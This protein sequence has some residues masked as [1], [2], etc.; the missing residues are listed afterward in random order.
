MS[1]VSRVKK[2]PTVTAVAALAV[3]ATLAGGGL[4][5]NAFAA[6]SSAQGDLAPTPLAGH[7]P[8]L[9]SE[10]TTLFSGASRQYAAQEELVRRCMEGKGFTY[11]K[12]PTPQS[13]V[14]PTVG[15]DNYGQSLQAASATG[16][17]SA[18]I[19]GDSP[20][21]ID[22]SGVQ[23]L[24]KDQQQ[25]WGDA[26]LGPGDAPEITV[27]IPTFGEV[28]T[29]AEGCLTEARRT[30]YG[31]I[32]Q[33]L[34]L[35][36]LSGNI[37]LQ[38]QR[39][40]RADSRV[41]ELNSSWSTCMVEKGHKGIGSPDDA[42]AEARKIHATLGIG[43]SEARDKE[44]RIAAA[45]AECDAKIGY[46]SKRRAIEDDYYRKVLV[47][48]KTEIAALRSMNTKASARADEIL[49]GA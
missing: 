25:K 34:K 32:E 35:D 19:V 11:V 44:I 45:D 28:G 10:I 47:K 36:F 3:S 22:R 46:G 16:Y 2:R 9:R 23:K 17:R 13:D 21:D 27:D 30:L 4:L 40:A 42:R 15:E 5:A 18:E 14:V 49:R 20:A 1:F 8:A 24:P 39:S 37:L 31:S 33:W 26:L 7:D 43:S 29:P 12:N 41:S 38:A 6:D 48:Y